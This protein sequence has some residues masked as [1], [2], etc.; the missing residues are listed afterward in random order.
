MKKRILAGR[1]R[2]CGYTAMMSYCGS[3]YSS[4]TVISSPEV[5]P[6]NPDN[7][8]ICITPKLLRCN[9]TT[10]LRLLYPCKLFGNAGHIKPG[11]AE[12]MIAITFCRILL[13]HVTT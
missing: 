2:C 11:N 10:C 12:T 6:L 7:Y 8:A 5:G 13:R 1:W 9:R 4:S 3:A